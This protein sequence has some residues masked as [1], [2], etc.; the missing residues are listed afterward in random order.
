MQVLIPGVEYLL[1]TSDKPDPKNFH[2]TFCHKNGEG[3]F[4]NGN[5]SE[6]VMKMMINRYQFLVQ[7]DSS[8]EN[9]QTLLFLK[10]AYESMSSRNFNKIKNR[11]NNGH[12]S[13]GVSVPAA[14]SEG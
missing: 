8:T 7:K 14:S 9:I 4:V 10:R 13:N 12:Q 6:E 1:D 2:F 5:T 11:Q 3:K